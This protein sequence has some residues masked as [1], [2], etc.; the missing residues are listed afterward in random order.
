MMTRVFR[1]ALKTMRRMAAKARDC[2][3]C[4]S[5]PASDSAPFSMPNSQ[6]NI[7]RLSSGELPTV[8]RLVRSLSAI[9][10]GG[11]PG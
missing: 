6:R 3:A 9:V 11:S 7:G 2:N 4:G 8:S 10:S 5:S 1:L